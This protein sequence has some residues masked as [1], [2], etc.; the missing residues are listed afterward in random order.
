V[1][2]MWRVIRRA[3]HVASERR[4]SLAHP[5]AVREDES[6]SISGATKSLAGHSLHFYWFSTYDR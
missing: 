4:L 1:V 5:F 2:A 3:V 6:L